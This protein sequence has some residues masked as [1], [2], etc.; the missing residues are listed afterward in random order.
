MIGG[1]VLMSDNTINTTSPDVPLKIQSNKQSP[2]EFMGG[3]IKF[4]TN[5]N[6]ETKGKIKVDGIETTENYAGK[7]VIPAGELEIEVNRD[8]EEVPKTINITKNSAGDIW[9]ENLT[10]EGFTIKLD[11]KS[12]KDIEVSWIV[13][14]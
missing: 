6:I 5:G 10:E 12:E 11:E 13:L 1:K 3:W 14:W 2:I 4:F 7:V 9:Y 8:W